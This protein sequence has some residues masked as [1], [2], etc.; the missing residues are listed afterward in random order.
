MAG[1]T[2]C[3]SSLFSKPRLSAVGGRRIVTDAASVP[4]F[5]ARYNHSA[6]WGSMTVAG[7]GRQL[8]IDGP[9]MLGVN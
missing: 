8:A 9:S 3:A 7:L 1:C 4:D 2:V 5:V 6:D